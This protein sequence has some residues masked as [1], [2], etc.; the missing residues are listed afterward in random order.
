MELASRKYR[1]PDKCRG[2]NKGRCLRPAIGYDTIL[3]ISKKQEIRPKSNSIWHSSPISTLLSV[4]S[5]NFHSLSG[6][7]SRRRCAVLSWRFRI[8]KCEDAISRGKEIVRYFS[9]FVSWNIYRRLRAELSS[10]YPLAVVN[11]ARLTILRSSCRRYFAGGEQVLD[12]L[13]VV[14][15]QLKWKKDTQSL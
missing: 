7:S 11:T 8:Q 10:F 13:M 5:L 15:P 14:R 2:E 3:L 6:L 9:I 1:I 12:T 4:V